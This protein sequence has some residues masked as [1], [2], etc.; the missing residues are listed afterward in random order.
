MSFALTCGASTAS[1]NQS[2][3][4]ETV[5]FGVFA[6]AT[7]PNHTSVSKSGKPDS[8]TVGSSGIGSIRC[9]AMVASARALPATTCS[10]TSDQFNTAAVM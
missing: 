7:R 8:E 6:G 4:C 5:S 10:P 2:I 1:R 3:S 9:N